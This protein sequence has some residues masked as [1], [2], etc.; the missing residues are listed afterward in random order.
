MFR[1]FSQLTENNFSV[2]ISVLSFQDCLVSILIAF[3]LRV[4][5]SVSLHFQLQ[6]TEETVVE[7]TV[8][9]QVPLSL[10]S[11]LSYPHSCII[12]ADRT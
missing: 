10:T 7:N 2:S 5:C 6:L 12:F 4:I 3:K 1:F 11:H 9:I 8:R